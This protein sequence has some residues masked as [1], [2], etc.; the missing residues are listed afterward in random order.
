M[1]SARH[2]FTWIAPFGYEGSVSV[3]LV[4]KNQFIIFIIVF[5]LKWVIE[6]AYFNIENR[7]KLLFNL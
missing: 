2:R 5:I 7:L 6:Q 4:L 1:Q 3:N